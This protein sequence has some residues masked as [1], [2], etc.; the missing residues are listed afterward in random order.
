MEIDLTP[1]LGTVIDLLAA[2]LMALGGW[3]LTKLGRKFGLEAD[4][5][6]R[7]YLAEALAGGI[8]WAKEQAAKR[9]EDFAHIEVRRKV[10]AEASHYVIERV[11]DAVKRLGLDRE[12]IEKLIEARLGGV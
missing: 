7:V 11:P 9:S 8:G 10:V 1:I 3:A 6:V 12:R 4:G 2:A 5:Q